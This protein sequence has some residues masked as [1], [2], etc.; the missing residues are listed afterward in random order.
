MRSRPGEQHTKLSKV[1][2]VLLTEVSTQTTGGLAGLILTAADAGQTSLRIA[3]PKGVNA[4]MGA[5][6]MAGFIYRPECVI[7]TSE[8]LESGAPWEGSPTTIELPPGPRQSGCTH[9]AVSA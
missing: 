4:L 6:D 7:G 9:H 1:S 8:L 3:G 5:A 2:H